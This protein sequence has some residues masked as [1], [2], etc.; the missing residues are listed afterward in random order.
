MV[1]AWVNAFFDKPDVAVRKPA[2]WGAVV[3]RRRAC[4]VLPGGIRGTGVGSLASV[5]VLEVEGRG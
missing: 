2:S 1:W 5:V 3:E 4:T